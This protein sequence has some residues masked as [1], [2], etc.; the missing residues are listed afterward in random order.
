M[1]VKII[2]S[3]AELDK[4]IVGLAAR[5]KRLDADIH[6]A[7]CSAAHHF[8]IHGD[9]GFINRLY[10]AMPK[11]SRH[12]ALTE[13]FIQFAGVS[14]NEDKGTSRANPFRKDAQKRVNLD[15]GVK[16]PWFMLKPSKTPDQVVDVLAL[17]LKIIAKA[18][19]EGKQVVN[20]AMLQEL[21]ALAERYAPEEEVA[22]AGEMAD[23]DE[24]LA[25]I[26]G[27]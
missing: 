19:G 3:S 21:Q 15:E 26:A 17:T 22:G 7:A 12:V 27:D 24:A 5:G 20:G 14:A 2:D 25:G 9:T 18:Q 4:F 8:S 13:W 23:G 6:V 16:K 10:N 1:Q 11:G